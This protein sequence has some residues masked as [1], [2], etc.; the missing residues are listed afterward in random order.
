MVPLS[1]ILFSHETSVSRSNG[2]SGKEDEIVADVVNES[3]GARS[4]LLT[5]TMTSF[6]VMFNLLQAKK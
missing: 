3:L 2:G 4:I 1:T 5:T 6:E